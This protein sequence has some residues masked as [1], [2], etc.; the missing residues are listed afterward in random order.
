MWNI[1]A[2]ISERATNVRPQKPLESDLFNSRS[3]SV[4]FCFSPIPFEDKIC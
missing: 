4:I 2:I 1:L 3:L